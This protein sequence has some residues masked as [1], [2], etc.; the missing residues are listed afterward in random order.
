MDEEVKPKDI[1]KEMPKGV[2]RRTI[3]ILLIIAIIISVAST[4]MGVNVAYRAKSVAPSKE[5]AGA[6]ISVSVAEPPV[7]E[8]AQIK[9]NVAEGE[10]NE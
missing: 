3:A 1:P 8:E 4:L 6:E 5:S 9:V 2:S 7:E 10:E